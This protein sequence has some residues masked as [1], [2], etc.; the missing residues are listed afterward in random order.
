M[1]LIEIDNY[2]RK[3]ELDKDSILEILAKHKKRAVQNN[4][5][6]LAKDIWC[7]EQVYKV[8]KN[9]IQAFKNMK[10]Q[11]F[12]EAWILLDRS[13]IELSFLRKHFDFSNNEYHL[14]FIEEY[15]PKYQKLFPYDLFFSREAI[16]SDFTCS[17]CQKPMGIRNHCEHIVGEIYNGEMCCRVVNK[18]EFLGFAI[19]K[20]P[21][22]KYCVPMIQGI[23]YNYEILNDLVSVLDSPFDEWDLEVSEE[24]WHYKNF[25]QFKG[26]KRNKP[27]PCGSGI[28]FKKCCYK[29]IGRKITHYNIIV[30][31]PKKIKSISNKL[32]KTKFSI[33]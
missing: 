24:I 14:S 28:K 2:L 3:K 17:I 18:I 8:K 22:D 16:E 33:Q 21:F 13:D 23:E 29:K 25:K 9:F 11:N 4:Q 5:E 26:A 27:C 6:D 15:I 30:K 7:L 32:V 10:K 31:N 19:V 12:Y 1:N 20:N